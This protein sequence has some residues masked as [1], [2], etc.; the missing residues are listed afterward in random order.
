MTVTRYG[1]GGSSGSLLSTVTYAAQSKAVG[2]PS[3]TVPWW[4]TRGTESVSPG[5]C[6]M[7]SPEHV[8]KR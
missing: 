4:G 2:K 1:P 6:T 5:V 8:L 7:K 3:E